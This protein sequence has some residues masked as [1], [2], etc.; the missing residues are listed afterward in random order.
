MNVSKFAL[1]GHTGTHIDS[2]CHFVNRFCQ[3]LA[4]EA[5][6]LDV[7]VGALLPRR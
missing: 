5:L 1:G 3:D 7:L 2:P 6:P 4:V